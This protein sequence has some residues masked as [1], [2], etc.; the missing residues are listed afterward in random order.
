M[1]RKID[2]KSFTFKA[3]DADEN[4]MIRGFASTFGNVDFGFD[5][6]DKGA[7][8][9]S[10]KESKGLWPILADHD[11]SK[12]IGWNMRAEENEKGLYVEGQLD[13]N[14]QSAREKF[15]LIK[16]AVKT[17]AKM[18]L[19]IGYTTIK[20]EPDRENPRVRRLKELKLW[21][22]SVVTF[23]MNPEAS[24]TGAKADVMKDKI[25]FMC[26]Q[27]GLNAN[28]IKDA[29]SEN[30]GGE[31]VDELI[32]EINKTTSIL[33]K[34]AKPEDPSQLCQSIEAIV[35]MLKVKP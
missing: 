20:A 26:E 35:S 5:V 33:Q 16:G 23:P 19:S 14:V 24:I 2:F 4:G 34:A 22:Y 28:E 6:V 30:E 15:S 31:N 10:I 8:V 29:L 7:F 17:G 32:A 21:E 18:G 1:S 13:L 27:L 12:Q 11:P 25:N 3:D 9:K